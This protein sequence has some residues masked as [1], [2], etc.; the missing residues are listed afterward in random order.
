MGDINKWLPARRLRDLGAAMK[1]HAY[2][3]PGSNKH[4]QD[5]QKQRGCIVRLGAPMVDPG[6]INMVFVLWGVAPR[7]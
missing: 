6:Q 3:Y 4:W 2:S 7:K 1:A 5:N